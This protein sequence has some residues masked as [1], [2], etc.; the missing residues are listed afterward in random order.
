MNGSPN[1]LAPDLLSGEQSH[2]ASLLV[3][4]PTANIAADEDLGVND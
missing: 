2:G 1:F 4:G 3:L